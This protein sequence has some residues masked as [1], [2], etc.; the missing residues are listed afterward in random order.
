MWP[1]YPGDWGTLTDQTDP[2]GFGVNAD[3][4]SV[5]L[6]NNISTATSNS[7]PVGDTGSV[8]G[9]W[10]GFFQSLAGTVANY[11]IAKDA[12]QSGL[13]PVTNGNGQVVYQSTA[14][15]A[16]KGMLLLLGGA[17]LFLLARKG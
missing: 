5:P 2:W 16:S 13:V 1:D 6:D 10:S 14:K 11:A 15:P 4:S 12:R 7:G 8:S 17:A 9:N 3:P